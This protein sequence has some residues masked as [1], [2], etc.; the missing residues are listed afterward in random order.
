MGKAA[1]QEVALTTVDVEARSSASAE[2]SEELI[3]KPISTWKGYVW[4]TWELPKE[5]RWL[6]FK[7]DAFV[8]TFASIGYFLKNLDQY[9]VNNAFLSGMEE[10]L[11]MFGNQLVTSTSIWTVGYVVGQIPSNLLLTR[12]SPRVVI[13]TL[14]LGWGVATMATSSVQSYKSLYALRFMV[15]LFESGFY[16][17]IHY[18]L[19]SWYTPRELGKRAMIFWLAGSMGQLFSGFLQ[20]A[21]YTGLNGIHGRAGWRWLFII[22]GIIT[23]PLAVTGFIFFPN[24]PQDDNK[25]WWTTQAEHE[26]SVRRMKAI[27]RAGREP[28][29]WPKFKRLLF[30]WHTYLLPMLYVIWNNGGY[31]PA[32]GYWLKSF[33][34]KPYPVP[35]TYFTIPEINYLPNVTIGIFIGM[36]FVWGWL[37]DGPLR[38]RRWP[39]IYAGAFITLIFSVVLRQMPLYTDVY[40]RKVVYWLSQ[41][42][43]GAG[44]LIL[45]WINEICSSDTEKRAL[46]VAAGNDFAYVVQAV[47]PNFVWKTVDFPA[48][49]KG[50]TWS[51]VLQVLLILWT[52][53]IQL[54]L[55][56]DKRIGANHR[57]IDVAESEAE[58]TTRRKV[59]AEADRKRISFDAAAIAPAA[60]PISQ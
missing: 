45:S 18:L 50:Y 32:M 9:N 37:S 17:G 52:A 27:G 1:E 34:K 11:S 58:S 26:L 8:L 57:A 19:G 35:G 31:Q 53:L 16:P 49:R 23:L 21:A 56:R 55:W 14:E 24:L 42:G 33:D 2:S 36:S 40:D 41:I 39:F 30:S 5:E 59:P 25:T 48:A 7:V 60:G 13:P 22:D 3:V 47:A 6:L 43:F 28:W 44:P 15:G 38:G 12:L 51:L 10:D 4:D 20:A 46:L 54:L 29:T